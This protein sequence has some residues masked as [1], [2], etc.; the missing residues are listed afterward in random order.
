MSRQL[1]DWIAVALAL[2]AVAGFAPQLMSQE[3]S[4]P[5]TLVSLDPRFDALVPKTAKL[6]KLA[7]GFSWVEG[8]VWDQKAG[9][10]LFSDIP[11]NVVHRTAIRSTTAPRSRFRSFE[12]IRGGFIRP[13][14]SLFV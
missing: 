4:P 9:A 7:D 5:G 8:P 10:I 12:G 13:P 1:P 3:P 2:V 14:P 6:E 11:N